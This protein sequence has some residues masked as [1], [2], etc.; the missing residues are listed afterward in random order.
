M[1]PF[2]ILSFLVKRLTP[3]QKFILKK[4]TAVQYAVAFREGISLWGIA[5]KWGLL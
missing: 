2:I 1:F 4:A 3:C 5:K